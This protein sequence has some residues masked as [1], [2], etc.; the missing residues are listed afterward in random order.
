MGKKGIFLLFSLVLVINIAYVS[1]NLI[2]GIYDNPPLVYYENNKPKGFFVDLLNEI[3]KE[4]NWKLKYTHDSF[5]NLLE[6]LKNEKIDIL[7]DIA[8][9][10]ERAIFLKYNSETVFTNW[11]VVYSKKSLDSLFK[12]N[13]KIVAVPK[14]D[15]YYIG[16]EGIKE[17]AKNF[18]LNIQFLELNSYNDV[19]KA[20]ADGKAYTGIISRSYNGEKYGLKKTS[21]I[22]SPID[23]YIAFSKDLN[24]TIIENIDLHIKKWKN[25]KKSIYYRL[26]DKYFFNDISKIPEWL[27]WILISSFLLYYYL[28]LSFIY[29]K[30]HY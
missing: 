11:G 27:K 9:S 25:E 24:K 18:H 5:N 22:F 6:S 17:L 15:I 19:L 8:Y 4:E 30:N 7:P 23:V 1:K 21:I 20:V 16:P 14:D 3:A 28:P 26:I 10:K 29:I 13:N 2:V 12:L